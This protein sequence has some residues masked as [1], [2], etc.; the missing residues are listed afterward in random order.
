MFVLCTSALRTWKTE[1]IKQDLYSS[2]L[3][4]QA[5][6]ESL[7]NGMPFP[8]RSITVDRRW[9]PLLSGILRPCAALE[10]SFPRSGRESR[11]V[12]PPVRP[13]TFRS[14][15]PRL[16]WFRWSRLRARRL[17]VR[18]SAFGHPSHTFDCDVV[19]PATRLSL[20][21]DPTCDHWAHVSRGDVYILVPQASGSGAPPPNI[22]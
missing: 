12:V 11:V 2:P 13:R 22:Y 7:V 14:S 9:H 21:G 17:A 4:V 1:S 8:C 19:V 20:L 10:V 3:F 16:A 15:F 6:Q 5:A 18:G